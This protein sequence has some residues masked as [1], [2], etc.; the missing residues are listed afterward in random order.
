MRRQIDDE[1]SEDFVFVADLVYG[2]ATV[3]SVV[4]AV[5]TVGYYSWDRFGRYVCIPPDTIDGSLIEARV[6]LLEELSVMHMLGTGQQSPGN[7]LPWDCPEGKVGEQ[8]EPIPWYLQGCIWRSGWPQNACPDFKALAEGWNERQSGNPEA[9]LSKVPAPQSKLPEFV[10]GLLI[11]NY[12]LDVLKDF[13]QN[14]SSVSTQISEDLDLKGVKISAK[15][16]SRYL[17]DL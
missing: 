16:I 17:K 9:P 8:I 4:T 3:G 14:N 15:S 7:D 12:G 11:L 13:N 2:S 5:E 6:R 1:N 10:K